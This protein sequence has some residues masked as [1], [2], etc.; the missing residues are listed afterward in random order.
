MKHETMSS[1]RVTVA[2]C[3]DGR[4]YQP[5]VA[6]LKEHWNA[7]WVD[8]VTGAGP[9]Q[10]LSKAP[11]NAE[12]RGILAQIKMSLASQHKKRLAVVSHEGCDCNAATDEEKKHM[13]QRSVHTLEREY[14]DATV[15][16]LW[17]D[18]AGS[19]SQLQPMN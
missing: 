13:V 6:F 5:V 11:L 17:I 3:M 12:A 19:V 4:I 7:Q 1:E 18:A 9:E 10:D 16:G 8:V 14:E 15:I 2:C